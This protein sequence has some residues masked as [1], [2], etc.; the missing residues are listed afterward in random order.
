MKFIFPLYLCVVDIKGAHALCGMYDSY[1]N[2]KRPCVSCLCAEFE[3]D[4]ASKRCQSVIHKDMYKLLHQNN[5][6]ELKLVSQHYDM[7][8]N[9]FF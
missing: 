9:A 7:T 6:D 4:D 3:L 8:E 2:V 1:S 5:E